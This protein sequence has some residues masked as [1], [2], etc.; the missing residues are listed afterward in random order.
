MVLSNV[1]ATGAWTAF[2]SV[3][4]I[5]G[6]VVAGGFI[7]ALCGKM[8]LGIFNGKKET[9]DS[10]E[11]N[12]T[13]TNVHNEYREEQNIVNK[14]VEPSTTNDYSNVLDVDDNKAEIEKEK[15]N[16]ELSGKDEDDFFKD[17]KEDDT[18]EDDELMSMIDE[19]SNDVLDEEESQ[20]TQIENEQEEKTKSVLDNYSIDNYFENSENEENKD[21]DEIIE[22]NVETVVDEDTMNEINTLKQQIKEILEAMDDTNNK[23]ETFN[24]QL[25]NILN[26]LKEANKSKSTI[27]TEE[28]AEKE[29]NDLK[30]QL[31]NSRIEMERQFQEKL[32]DKDAEMQARLQEQLD[33]SNA[34][35]ES[36]KAQL[37]ALLQKMDE[38]D[39]AGGDEVEENK[40]EVV[41]DSEIAALREEVKQI[42]NEI[43]EE[44]DVKNAEFN[45]QLTAIL[46]EMKS[47]NLQKS[48]E[49]KIESSEDAVEEI[50]DWKDQLELTEKEI[51]EQ[52]KD[53]IAHSEDDEKA[54][55]RTEMQNYNDEI[56]ELKAQLENLMNKFEE[57]SSN[58][59]A[60]NQALIDELEAERQK[61]IALER[62]KLEREKEQEAQ[63]EGLRKENE[64]LADKL[65]QRD[66]SNYQNLTDDE[67]ND[68][69]SEANNIDY[70]A[71]KQ[72]HEQQIDEKVKEGLEQSKAE[73]DELKEQISRIN[74][75]IEK[76]EEELAGQMNVH[77]VR[78]PVD[79]NLNN[80]ITAEE[81][82]EKVKEKLNDALQE[83][84]S[85]K[86][87]LA[88][89]KQEVE[90][91][92]KEQLANTEAGME[93][94]KVN[95]LQES[96]EKIDS[97]DS[98][99][100]QLSENIANER[101]NAK[102]TS[103]QCI[104]ELETSR[105]DK[106]EHA[107]QQLA[108]IGDEQ[109]EV[110]VVGPKNNQVAL[111]SSN[112]IKGESVEAI[113][114]DEIKKLTEQEIEEIVEK[115][116]KSAN[117]EIDNLK[118]Q[119]ESLKQDLIQKDEEIEK[120]QAEMSSVPVMRSPLFDVETIKKITAQEVE[121]KVQE[122]LAEAMKEIEEM[123]RQL[124]ISR[125]EIEKQYKEQVVNNED[126]KTEVKEQ[127]KDSAA[128]VVDLKE[129]LADLTEQITL[130]H[131]EAKEN[132]AVIAEQLEQTRKE[133]G[134]IT[135]QQLTFNDNSDMALTT[136]A[137]VTVIGPKNNQVA[138]VTG[139]PMVAQEEVEDI[140]TIDI[141]TVKKLTE[142]E[143]EEKVE[144]RMTNSIIEIEEL[145]KQILNLSIQVQEL[146]KDKPNDD[147]EGKVVVFHYS[148]EEAYLERIAV[149]EERLKIA[150]KD[151][152]INNKELKP[153]EKVNRTLERDRAK[154]RRKDSIVA[155][156]RVALY[157][158]NNYTDIDKEKEEK[159][160]QELELLDGL[161]LSVSHCEEVMNAN[162][163][164]YP[165]LL[166]TDQILRENIANLESDIDTLN[167]ELK[168]LREKNSAQ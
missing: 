76:R 123:K 30:Q 111:I 144:Q 85:L 4:A 168:A 28:E 70:S 40:E 145:K 113:D 74:A 16:R 127:L 167:K 60:E 8:V 152:K 42:L 149:L 117:M 120:V 106:V 148:T 75:F 15:L 38:D 162:I 131:Q 65:L 112:N 164:R 139:L 33:A 77:E 132:S 68:L 103:E 51:I 31:E 59:K 69:Y 58:A 124:E 10:N 105:E 5:I 118:Q 89:T 72:M 6:I 86:E 34:E 128:E 102:A 35:I 53:E 78:N 92:Y 122:K 25:I 94:D 101:E 159:L 12:Y 88:E 137:D 13:N 84:E 2:L 39:N 36:L 67:M 142:Q 20:N 93:Y 17:F 121:V 50:A 66:Q 90:N 143:I 64:Q 154:L 47:A 73:I 45:S 136:S 96:A 153:L 56:K 95:K 100:N 1:M 166:H 27:K 104:A 119:I 158:V 91:Q 134:E 107:K 157:G 108:E 110:A 125:Q 138:L 24:E 54:E 52:F 11:Y 165:I 79:A 161:R 83:I 19:I 81:V 155:K 71:I 80:E 140:P 63:L 55:I 109:T 146:K 21:D 99:L 160:A 41:E 114:A 130:E 18:V 133:I 49:V 129:H 87:N 7:V 48:E 147:D 82:E 44:N 22:E 126:V 46:N 151:L 62:E 3:L 26:E 98:Q 115:R 14:T 29:I 61:R 9:V 57:D 156:K 116:L 23:N 141:E 32:A 97:L 163:D 37:S 150:K 135:K 43:R